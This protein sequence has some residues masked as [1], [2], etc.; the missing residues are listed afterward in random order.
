MSDPL[1]SLETRRSALLA[2]LSSVH[3]MRPGSIVGA[4]RRCGKPACHCAQPGNPGHGPSLR[5]TYKRHG[6]TVTEALPT[7]AAVRKAEQ[8]IAEFRRF[9][10]L[11]DELIEVSAQI[12]RLRPVEDTSSPQEKKRRGPSSKRSREN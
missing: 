1:S 9:E 4:V 6:K 3:D 7:S 2:D 11:S 8:E 10:Q 5:I 12:C